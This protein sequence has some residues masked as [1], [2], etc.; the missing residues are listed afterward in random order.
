[1]HRRS[2]AVLAFAIWTAAFN[3]HAETL[4]FAPLPMQNRETVVKQFRPM[5]SF[6]EKKLSTTIVYEYSDGYADLLEKFLQKKIDLAYLG[7]LPYVELRRS[8]E[9]AEP[10]VRFKEKSGNTTYTC[11]LVT[12]PDAFF[13]PYVAEHRKIALTQPLSTCGYL[14]VSGL[15]RERGSSLEDNAYRY[16]GKHDAVALSVL[17][18]QFDAG[19]LKTAIAGE[20]THLGLQMVA[21]TPPLPAF[22]L[23]GNTATL[24]ADQMA[25]IRRLL[26]D[27]DPAGKDKAMLASWGKNIRYGAVMASDDDYRSV[28]TLLRDTKIPKKGNF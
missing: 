23:V 28:R 13:D 1:M 25:R 3:A 12:F 21:E 14:S 5:T 22:A 11:S 24:K 10:L 9:Q 2:I 7:P 17:Q 20:Y 19:G 4:R 15:L 27:L 18:G 26:T 16:V 6:L 8:Y